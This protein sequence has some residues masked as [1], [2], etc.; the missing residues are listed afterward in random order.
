MHVQS[1]KCECKIQ[2]TRVFLKKIN[3]SLSPTFSLFAW[4]FCGPSLSS[5]V[6]ILSFSINF[7]FYFVVCICLFEVI[8]HLLFFIF[9]INFSLAGPQAWAAQQM[10][11]SLSE[12]VSVWGDQISDSHYSVLGCCPFKINPPERPMGVSLTVEWMW[13]NVAERD[14]QK[15]ETSPQ[16]VY[17]YQDVVILCCDWDSVL[18]CIVARKKITCLTQR[19]PEAP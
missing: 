18:P 4:S 7:I 1:I 13:S 2:N 15:P 10:H 12:W 19:S 16:A 17:N 14:N 8:L 6:S 9:L 11:L 5:C 3:T